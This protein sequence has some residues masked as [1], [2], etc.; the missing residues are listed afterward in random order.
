MLFDE[1]TIA[2][3]AGKGG[4]GCLSF[5]REK[6]VP[7]GGPDGGNGGRGGHV[8]FEAVGDLD[9]LIDFTGQHH[10]RAENGRPGSGSNRTGADGRDLLIRV[11]AGTLIYDLDLGLL[12]KD[13]NQ[14]GMQARVC[15]GG[16]GGRGNKAFA[17]ATNQT[18]RTAE[19][20][21]P[22]QERNLRLE[23][24]LIADVG[25]VG[26]PNAGKSTLISRHPGAPPGRRPL[27]R[28]ALLSRG[29]H[30]RPDRRRAQRCGPGPYLPAPYRAHAPAHPPAQRPEPRSPR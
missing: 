16:K 5:R 14:V 8:I 18:P 28:L 25:L 29:R 19:T 22:G 3:R 21:T 1:A 6:Y 2:V 12:L 24:K 20:G 27:R 17:T 4:N 11:P 13:L 15:R 10:W 7:K 9:T 30:P 26:K 23:L